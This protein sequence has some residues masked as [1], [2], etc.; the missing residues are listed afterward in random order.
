MGFVRD[1]E[2]AVTNV[3]RNKVLVRDGGRE[4]ERE[5]MVQPLYIHQYPND[6]ATS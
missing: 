2:H 3:Q 6:Q 5:I 1:R 4:R